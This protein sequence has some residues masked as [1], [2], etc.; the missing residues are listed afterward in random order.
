MAQANERG[1]EHR[2]VSMDVER[3]FRIARW[4][5]IAGDFEHPQG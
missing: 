4:G 2:K 3:S 1:H 5:E